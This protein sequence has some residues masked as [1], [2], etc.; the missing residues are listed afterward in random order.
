MNTILYIKIDDNVKVSHPHVLLQDIAELSC[1]NTKILNR[2]R[3]LPVADLSHHEKER[4][5]LSVLDLIQ[6]IEKRE[7]GLQ[8]E[9]LGEEDFI[10]T[11]Q[12]SKK[13]PFFRWIKISFVC[14]TSFF[15]SAFSIMT[16]N[17]DADVGTLFKQ[18]YTQITGRTSNGFTILEITYS[19]G[20][21]LGVLIF[22]NHF[23]HFKF[24]SEPTPLQVQMCLYEK[25]IN[26]TI[27]KEKQRSE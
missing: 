25:N 24:S 19:I 22:F 1:S 8:I 15:G 20:I 27:I 9:S 5:V 7:P 13:I 6:Q 10:L 23:G 3:F 4:Y 16:F 17:C 26:T 14:L 18:I 11:Y 2:I 12:K 21:G